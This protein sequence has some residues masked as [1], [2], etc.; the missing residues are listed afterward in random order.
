MSEQLVTFALGTREYATPLQ[1][2]REVVRLE[3]LADLPGMA[4]PLAGVLDLRGTS[5]PVLDLRVGA[6]ADTRG[7][8]LVLER[9]QADGEGSVGVAVDRV[10]AV[11]TRDELPQAGPG[12]DDGVLPSYVVEVLRGSL[13]PVFLVDLEQMIDAARV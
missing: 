7:D 8:V 12:A 10:R 11:V 13:G 3:G 2:V 6:T 4:P 1:S 9:G 5:L